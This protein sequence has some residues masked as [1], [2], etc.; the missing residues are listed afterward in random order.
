MSTAK[1][2]TLLA[3]TQTFALLNVAIADALIACFD[4]NTLIIRGDL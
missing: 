1:Q 4:A 3:N 2:Q